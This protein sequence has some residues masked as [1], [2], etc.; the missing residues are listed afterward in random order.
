MALSLID[1]DILSEVLKQRDPVVATNAAAYLARHGKFNFSLFTRFEIMRGYKEKRAVKLQSRFDSFCQHS[2][3][4]PLSADILNLAADVWAEARATWN[5]HS[6]AD[7]LIAATALHNGLT[8][9]TGNTSH[10]NWISGLNV[11]NWRQS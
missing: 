7:V 9:V 5:P 4:L 1:T 10:F 3:I 6:D 11:A 8:L 2:I